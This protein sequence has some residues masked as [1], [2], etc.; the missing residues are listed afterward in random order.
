MA[1]FLDNFRWPECIDWGERR[2]TVASVVAGVL[3]SECVCVCVCVCVFMW[4]NF[5]PEGYTMKRAE[6]NQA[7]L[8]KPGSTNMQL[9][10]RVKWYHEAHLR[11]NLSSQDFRF[12]FNRR[13]HKR[14]VYRIILVTFTKD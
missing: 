2:N 4:L 12:S 14:G 3:V 9:V 10:I 8:G 11:V 7:F 6:H 5:L 1:G 13:S